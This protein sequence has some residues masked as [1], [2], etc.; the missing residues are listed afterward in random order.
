[1]TPRPLIKRIIL[2][3]AIAV[4]APLL[5]GISIYLTTHLVLSKHG[6]VGWLRF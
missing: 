3:I 5:L 2:Y 1:M 4:F 6:L